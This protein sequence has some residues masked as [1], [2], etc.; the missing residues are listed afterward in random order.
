MIWLGHDEPPH[1]AAARRH[2]HCRSH[3]CGLTAQ[4]RGAPA[5]SAS[6]ARAYACQVAAA[7]S[8]RRESVAPVLC[9]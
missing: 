9:F 4:P 6:P 1:A 7:R 8:W 2:R 3:G 5:P